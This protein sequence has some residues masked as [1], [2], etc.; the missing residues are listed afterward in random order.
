MK[1][2]LERKRLIGNRKPVANFR[3]TTCSIENTFAFIS[4]PEVEQWL[5]VS[6]K[7]L[8]TLTLTLYY[9]SK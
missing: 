5:Y 8:R 9:I 3:N 4:E 2:V 1:G 7:L 6:M